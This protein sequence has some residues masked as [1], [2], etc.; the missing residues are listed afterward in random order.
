MTKFSRRKYILSS[1][2]PRF[3]YA[4]NMGNLSSTQLVRA[5]QTTLAKLDIKSI[6]RSVCVNTLICSLYIFWQECD[7]KW[8]TFVTKT[9]PTHHITSFFSKKKKK[10]TGNYWH[11]CASLYAITY[12]K[13]CNLLNRPTPVYGISWCL[14]NCNFSVSH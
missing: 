13:M 12:S 6:F 4:Q 5:W 11:K 7:L 14:A 8:V 9:I 10:K 1:W 2:Q 3:I